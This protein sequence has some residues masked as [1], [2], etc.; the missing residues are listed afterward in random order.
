MTAIRGSASVGPDAIPSPAA[1]EGLDTASVPL[2]G[3]ALAGPWGRAATGPAR[4]LLAA[5]TGAAP[6]RLGNAGRETVSP[7]DQPFQTPYCPET[8]AMGDPDP[9]S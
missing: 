1:K 2:S 7:N 8:P 9:G 4:R 6:Q 5:P 3:W